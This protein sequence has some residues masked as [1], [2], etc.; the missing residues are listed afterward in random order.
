[1]AHIMHD[2]ESLGLEPGS[3]IRSIGAVV[4]DPFSAAQGETFYVNIDQTSCES[5]GLVTDPG[6]E[7]WWQDPARAE[8]LAA[9]LIDPKPLPDALAAFTDFYQA[10]DGH[11]L[12]CQGP[13]FDA[14]LLGAAYQA[15]GMKPPWAYNAPRDTRTVYD[16]AGFKPDSS[17]VAHHALADA[18]D[19]ARAVTECYLRIGL[20]PPAEASTDPVFGGRGGPLP[21]YNKGEDA[22]PAIWRDINRGEGEGVYRQ[23]AELAD[24]IILRTS[25]NCWD[26]CLQ[27]P[28]A[29]SGVAVGLIAAN[30]RFVLGVNPDVPIDQAAIDF[31][32]AWES[33]A[34]ELKALGAGADRACRYCGCTQARACETPE[35]PCHWISGEVCSAPTCREKHERAIAAPA[36]TPAL[37]AVMAE[38][39]RQII[40]EGWSA[41]HDD[42][43]PGG[44]LARAAACYAVGSIIPNAR[45]RLDPGHGA[46]AEPIWPWAME[47]WKPTD[48]RGELVKAGALIL[49]EIERLDRAAATGKAG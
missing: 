12:W 48:R 23:M 49:A 2:L 42:S 40:E 46:H 5:F 32:V 27:L 24:D 30:A 29:A 21:N 34:R 44:M 47:W 41:D 11:R 15:A 26:N 7:A 17:K 6:T 10:Q 16:M 20:K 13:S 1:M 39:R 33:M 9:V 28:D 35:G 8:A 45:D 36:W 19:Q 38:R 18:R 3:V 43:Q 25:V 31:A 22:W 4:F 37:G 14:A